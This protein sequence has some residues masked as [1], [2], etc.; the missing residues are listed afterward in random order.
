VRNHD[1]DFGQ[2]Y[3]ERFNDTWKKKNSN[4][5]KR[6]TRRGKRQ[7]KETQQTSPQEA[8]KPGK[9]RN[10]NTPIRDGKNLPATGG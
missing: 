5:R 7:G 10:F 9:S 4:V 6:K 2:V 1:A 3:Q 8:S